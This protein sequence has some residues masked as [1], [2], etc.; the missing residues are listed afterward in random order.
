M[1]DLYFAGIGSRETPDKIKEMMVLVS[2]YLTRKGYTLNS[3][4]ADGA[5]DAFEEGALYEKRQIFLPWDEFNGRKANGS[6][7]II[8]PY[9]EEIV[10]KYHPKFNALKENGKLLMSRNS[11][12]VMG[13]DLLTPVKF[14][15]CWYIPGKNSGTMQAVRI[16]AHMNIPVFNFYNDVDKIKYYLDNYI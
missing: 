3:G 7:Y 15:L 9:N 10:R 5:D 1:N 8:P 4:G 2:R 16:A 14:V 12:Q 11:Y 13:R 6:E